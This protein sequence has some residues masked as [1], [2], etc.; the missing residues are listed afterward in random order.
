MLANG[1]DWA[2]IGF[3]KKQR[4]LDLVAKTEFR[5]ISGWRESRPSS[6]QFR[7]Q[8]LRLAATIARINEFAD[9]LFVNHRGED[10]CRLN[11]E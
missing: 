10:S 2:T 4:F 7:H 3:D 11:K 1:A 8:Q 9:I 6:A 5:S